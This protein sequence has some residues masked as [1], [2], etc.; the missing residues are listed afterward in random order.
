MSPESGPDFI[1]D[2]YPDTN[3]HKRPRP[4]VTERFERIANNPRALGRLEK[5]LMDDFVVDVSDEET[6]LHLAKALYESE[7]R[8]AIERGHGADLAKADLDDSEIL[9]KY[10]S[11]I[12]EKEAIQRKTL[13]S[14]FDYLKESEDYPMW[15]K[16]YVIRSLRSI[17]QFSRDEKDYAHRTDDTIAPFPELNAESLAFVHT[18]LKHEFEKEDFDPDIADVSLTEE[19]EAQVRAHVSEDHVEHA[20]KGRLRNKRKELRTQALEE[21][22]KEKDATF[23]STL[24]L[25][26]EKKEELTEELSK[27][28]KSKDFARLYAFAQVECAGNLDRESLEGEW[29][30]YDKGSDYHLLENG[31]KG[32]GTGWCTA[33]GSAKNQLEQGDFYVYYTNNKAGLPTEPRIAIRMQADAIAEIRGVNPRQELE[34]ELVE[35]AQKKYRDLP[36]AQKY[37]KAD[38]DMRRMTALYNR[39]VSVD[40]ETKEKTYLHPELSKDDLTFLYELNAPIEGFGYEKDPRITE[41][42]AT[43]NPEEDA[44]VVFDCTKE[45]IAHTPEDI[46]ADTKAYVGSL[47][48][49]GIFTKLQEHAIEHIYTKFPEGNI[50]TY[51]VPVGDM[52]KEDIVQALSD[53]KYEVTEYAKDLMDSPDFHISSSPETLHLVCLTVADLGLPRGVT[54]QEIFTK[55][56]K[57]GL[58]LCPPDTGPRLRLSL[59]GDGWIYVAMKPIPDRDGGPRVFCVDRRR[60]ELTLGAGHARPDRGWGD[61]IQ[62]IFSARKVGA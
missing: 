19:E 7:K 15:F 36:G 29:V 57:L 51:D 5:L 58:D 22:A 48:A 41:L 45:Q 2:K 20:L 40:K 32:K 18:A 37:E 16:Y 59:P 34:P 6:L 60:A 56:D 9:E 61:A 28:L 17:G 53:P 11:A 13:A 50:K 24:P 55:A 38:A 21:F 27:R 3:D 52:S 47:N 42:R 54:T 4:P 1:T 23:A 8:I 26:E 33:E 46:T 43:R 39:C 35:I 31:L 25:N 49:P 30:K 14:W 10:K 44:P 12:L 62:F